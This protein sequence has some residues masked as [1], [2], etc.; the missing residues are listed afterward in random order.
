M[1]E[2]STDRGLYAGE[3]IQQD[4]LQARLVHSDAVLVTDQ[5]EVAE[6]VHKEAYAGPGSADHFGERLLSDGR[7]HSLRFLRLSRLRHHKQCAGET[8][9]AGVEHLIYKIGLGPHAAAKQVRQETVREF[10]VPMQNAE[11][12]LS[13]DLERSAKVYRRHRCHTPSRVHSQRL[14]TKEI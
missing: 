11:H 6:A 5:P 1:N 10:G 12:I 9:F 13:L 4:C 2:R 8:F 14:F 7:N 3:L